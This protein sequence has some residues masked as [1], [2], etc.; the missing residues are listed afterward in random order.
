VSIP[1][2]GTGHDKDLVVLAFGH[3]SVLRTVVG[4]LTVI[5]GRSPLPVD[6]PLVEV[7]LTS[8]PTPKRLAGKVTA[9]PPLLL[10]LLLLLGRL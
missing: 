8:S 9:W 6:G 1:P 3:S 4:M 2:E 5:S 10:L 7:S